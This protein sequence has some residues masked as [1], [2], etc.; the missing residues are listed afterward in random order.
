MPK[1]TPAGCVAYMPSCR[2]P[3]A[4]YRPGRPAGEAFR[5][6][7]RPRRWRLPAASRGHSGVA[8]R[9]A[10]MLSMNSSRRRSSPSAIR[11]RPFASR[12]RSSRLISAAAS[13]A[14]STAAASSSGP[15]EPTSAIN[16][17]LHGDAT[18]ML[19]VPARHSPPINI[20]RFFVIA[21]DILTAPTQ[22]VC[23][24]RGQR[25][26]FSSACTLSSVE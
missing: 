5:L 21:R 20:S 11:R 22:E 25:L 7:C 10:M 15:A 8:C 3:R 24:P 1:T 9:P 12:K 2:G 17:P 18:E 19:S 16:S 23:K 6:A 4:V 13:A 26:N 14:L